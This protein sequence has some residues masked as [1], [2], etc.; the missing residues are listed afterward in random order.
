MHTFD[1]TD[2]DGNVIRLDEEHFP[3]TKVFLIINTATECGFTPQFKGLQELYEKFK[4]RGL[5]II[6][7]PSNSF[8][9]EPLESKEVRAVVKEKFGATFPIMS[10]CNVNGENQHPLFKWLKATYNR[11]K[12][13]VPEW[14]EIEQSGLDRKDIHWNFEKF[15]VFMVDGRQRVLRFSYDMSA[16]LLEPRLKRALH[17]AD[18]RTRTKMEL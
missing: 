13:K 11:G 4:P 1:I 5:E 6:A 17:L 14:N 16:E 10:K 8:N 7:F 15:V 2:A 3:G 18:G 12:A 9:Q